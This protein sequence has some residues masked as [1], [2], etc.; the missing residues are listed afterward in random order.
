[1]TRRSDGLTL[2]E[3]AI[4]GAVL[5]AGLAVLAQLVRATLDSS[6]Q[7]YTQGS[8]I[9]PVVEHQLRLHATHFKGLMRGGPNTS[10]LVPAGTE[11]IYT[12]AGTRSYVLPP[13]AGMGGRT[14]ALTEQEITARVTV[15][16]NVASPSDP[17]VGYTMFWKLDV[18][19]GSQRAGL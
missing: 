2:L 5:L 12:T 8:P 4:S 18:L 16:S 11:S 3:V 14:Y 10:N 1:M 13:R 9:G 15:S 19:N 7:S 6:A 17:T